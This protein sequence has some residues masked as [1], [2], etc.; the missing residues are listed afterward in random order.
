MLD[1]VN[2]EPHQELY[3]NPKSE[4]KWVK[5]VYPRTFFCNSA[6]EKGWMLYAPRTW[7]T[8]GYSS[9]P[10]ST[11]ATPWKG[12]SRFSS[13]IYTHTCTHAHTH[14]RTHTHTHTHTCTHAN[15]HTRK[16][17]GTWWT[18]Q[19]V[20]DCC[21]NIS[22]H[23]YPS[24][25]LWFYLC[26]W[27]RW[28]HNLDWPESVLSNRLP[29]P[30]ITANSDTCIFISCI[31]SS[32]FSTRV[33]SALNAAIHSRVLMLLFNCILYFTLFVFCLPIFPM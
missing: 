9:R 21:F 12:I 14:A 27:S 6:S 24:H 17:S 29:Q 3:I 31:F 1:P 2:I 10:T 8:P 11:N 15:T 32:L 20:I 18:G 23:T 33:V 26:Q 28:P 16:Q 4:C 22:F 30:E 25:Q 5:C 7:L 13:A 19:P